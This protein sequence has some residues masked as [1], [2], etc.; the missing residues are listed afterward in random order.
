MGALRTVLI[1]LVTWRM[2]PDRIQARTQTESR[3]LGA[4][5]ERLGPMAGRE[6]LLTGILLLALA[7]WITDSLHGISA[8]YKWAQ[9]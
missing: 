3:T 7:L 4:E 1:V 8:G 6:R 5:S 2:F 9:P